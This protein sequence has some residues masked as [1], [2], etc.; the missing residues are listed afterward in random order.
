ML[1]KLSLICLIHLVVER[2]SNK[3]I[4]REASAIVKKEDNTPIN[5]KVIS[6]IPKSQSAPKWVPLFDSGDVLRLTGKFAHHLMEPYR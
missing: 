3:Y 2:D 1:A 5:L 4:V 6:F